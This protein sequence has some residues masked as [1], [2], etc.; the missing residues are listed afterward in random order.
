MSIAFPMP[1][2][3]NNLLIVDAF[4]LAFRWKLK[5]SVDFKQEYLDTI[6]SFKLS[7]NAKKVIVVAD[8]GTSTYRKGIF[9]EYKQNRKELAD[10]QTEEEKAAFKEFYTNYL[11]ALN[12]LEDSSKFT[13]LQYKN[14]E[15]DDIAASICK[16]YSKCFEHIWLI[17]TDKDWD[18]LVKSNVSRFSYRTR[19]ET[20]L[21][22]WEE[23]HD[24]PP[25][26]YISVKCLMG[27]K[28]DNVPGITGV[29]EKTAIKLIT[30]YG[31]ALDIA[32]LIPLDGKTKV[33]QSI[34]SSKELILKNYEL[35]DLITFSDT[36]L[37]AENLENLKETMKTCI[38]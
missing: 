17:S 23:S 27:D 13:V 26:L 18:L 4:N 25:E 38:E 15:A 19:Q 10:K 29:G 5:G 16:H 6:N 37:G 2:P 32:N 20:T 31:D 7:Y 30:Q 21:S 8:H 33:L 36:A 9:S 3:K 12:Y 11:N 14:T 28:G 24:Y 22:N 1:E 35:M 34:N